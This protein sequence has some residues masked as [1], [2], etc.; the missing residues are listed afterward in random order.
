VRAEIRKAIK[1]GEGDK[2]HV[3]LYEDKSTYKIPK[4]IMECFEL[5]PRHV[6][7]KFLAFTEGQQKSYVDW[8]YK[9][10]R[11]ETRAQRIATMMERVS[12]GKRLH[13]TEEML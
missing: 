10:K 2:V 7:E 6:Y 3:V 13:D 4:P 9:A 11:A 8:I 1:K 12:K 5:E